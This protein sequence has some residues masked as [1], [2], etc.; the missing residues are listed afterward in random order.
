[1][2]LAHDLQDII[3]SFHCPWRSSPSSASIPLFWEH[4]GF[5]RLLTLSLPWC[6][7]KK[8]GQRVKFQILKSFCFPFRITRERVGI[9][10][11]ITESRFVTGPGQYTACRRVRAFFSP[12][13]L[14]AS[15]VKGLRMATPGSPSFWRRERLLSN[16][17]FSFLVYC[18]CC[19]RFKCVYNEELFAKIVSASLLSHW[20]RE[21]LPVL[22]CCLP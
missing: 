22:C 17:L 11:H 20:R 10:T 2:H 18:G 19:F 9:K 21:R 1:M 5:L 3:N 16:L 12:E 15:A 14:Q 13:N 8:T 7:L 6:H 4:K